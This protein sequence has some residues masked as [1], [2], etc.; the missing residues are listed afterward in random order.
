MLKDAEVGKISGLFESQ[1]FI[2]RKLCGIK[3][4][5]RRART[6]SGKLNNHTARCKLCGCEM[7][8]LALDYRDY[9]KR[10]HF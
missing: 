1:R 6:V 10:F 4:I 7:D 3:H 8:Q 2:F 5:S 9:F